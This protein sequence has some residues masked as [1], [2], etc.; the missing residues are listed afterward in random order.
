MSVINSE[1]RVEMIHE[2]VGGRAGLASLPLQTREEYNKWLLSGILIHFSIQLDG[3]CSG[4]FVI[5]LVSN[6]L[7]SPTDIFFDLKLD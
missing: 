5:R 1:R 7:F 3:F 2:G 4:A 6:L